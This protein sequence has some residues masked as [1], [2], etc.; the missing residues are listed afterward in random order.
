MY[1][2]HS[3]WLECYEICPRGDEREILEH[4]QWQ[5]KGKEKRKG[6][7]EKGT[8]SLYRYPQ[9]LQNSLYAILMPLY[10]CSYERPA[11]FHQ[12]KETWRGSLLLQKKVRGENS[13]QSSL[14]FN[15]EAACPEQWGQHQQPPSPGL[16]SASQHQ[17]SVALICLLWV[18]VLYSD[19]FC[20]LWA[21]HVLR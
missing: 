1:F 14:A 5:G 7:S 4:V 3:E 6:G 21:R 11:C 15:M 12:P 13:D 10:A 17:A 19:L 20:A 16:H 9:L 8:S 2:N 18:S